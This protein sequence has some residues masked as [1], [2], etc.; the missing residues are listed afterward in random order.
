MRKILWQDFETG[1]VEPWTHSKLS[2]AMI[3]TKGFDVIGEWYTQIRQPPFNVTEEGMAINK[4]NLS[5]AG[6]THAHFKT[7]YF[8][9]V[10]DWF[11]GGTDFSRANGSWLPGNIKA[12]KENMPF[13]GG[14]N[15]W[16]DRQC[17]HHILGGTP[18]K[19]VFDGAY[20]HRVDTMVLGSSFQAVGL[21]DPAQPMKLENLCAML[22]LKPVGELHNALVDLQ[23]TVACYLKMCSMLTD[24]TIGRKYDDA[25]REM[26]NGQSSAAVLGNA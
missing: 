26:A 22:G 25:R 21:L 6:L 12:D 17:L 11:Y 16:F 19:S 20:Y 1:G 14:H 7:E 10:N 24:K 3:A 13:Y 9:R 8:K 18:F 2:F 15:T 4:L 5:D 23:M